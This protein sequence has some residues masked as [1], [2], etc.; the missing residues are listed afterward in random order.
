LDLWVVNHRHAEEAARR[1]FAFVAEPS[2]L[3]MAAT[4]LAA[5]RG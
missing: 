2:P 1:M 4:T 3:R 5:M